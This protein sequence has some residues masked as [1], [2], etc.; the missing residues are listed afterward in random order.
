MHE[1]VRA[2]QNSEIYAVFLSNKCD[3]H[4][5]CSAHKSLFVHWALGVV[6][7]DMNISSWKVN[8][9]LA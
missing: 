7:S 6:S 1:L 3:P 8:K 2:L 9:L 4:A 5:S